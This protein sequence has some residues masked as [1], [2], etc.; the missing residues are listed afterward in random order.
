MPP[1]APPVSIS[2]SYFTAVVSHPHRHRPSHRCRLLLTSAA[3]HLT[4]AQSY[5]RLA[6]KLRAPQTAVSFI[7]LLA[8]A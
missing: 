4:P 2:A 7:G 3:H 8:S 5:Q 1:Q 6:D